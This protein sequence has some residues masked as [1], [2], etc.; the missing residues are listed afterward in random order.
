MTHLFTPISA[1]SSLRRFGN[2]AAIALGLGA[3]LVGLSSS[4]VHASEVPHLMASSVDLEE[5]SVIQDGVYLYG[6]SPEP[7]QVGVAYMVFEAQSDRIVGAFYMPHSS[8]DCFYGE[9]EPDKLALTVVD[10]YEQ[11]HYPYDVAL[12]PN[13][14]VASAV[15]GAMAEFRLEGF[16]PIETVSV[17]DQRILGVCQTNYADQI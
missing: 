7:E 1:V 17:N 16:F 6:Q 14:D 11:A 15:G 13:S 3:A 10:S 8:F 9:A 12:Q 5:A 2:T 4:T